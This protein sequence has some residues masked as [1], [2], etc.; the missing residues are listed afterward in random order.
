MINFC[1]YGFAKPTISQQG[2]YNAEDCAD[3]QRQSDGTIEKIR[4]G[5][6]FMRQQF[7]EVP[8]IA[9]Y[10]KEYIRPELKIN[11]LWRVYH[12]DELWSKLQMRK[13]NLKLLYQNMMSYQGKY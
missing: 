11:D 13:R 12:M 5:L 6:D 3:W 7:H 8:F 2:E 1:R 10:R 9:F 4:K